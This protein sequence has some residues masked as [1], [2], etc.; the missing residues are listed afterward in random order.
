MGSAPPPPA[1]HRQTTTERGT[2]FTDTRATK[3]RMASE[4]RRPGKM[5]ALHV[6]KYTAEPRKAR[7]QRPPH[8]GVPGGEEG[9]EWDKSAVEESDAGRNS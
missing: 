9:D 8:Y 3:G 2:I 5:N 1:S 7:P 6:G 4:E